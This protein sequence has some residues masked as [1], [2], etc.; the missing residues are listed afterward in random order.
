[1]NEGRV[2]QFDTPR[3]IVH[4]PADGFVKSL[5]HS[6]REQEKFWEGLA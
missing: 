4:N 6:Y 1:M 5:I 3:N 2:C